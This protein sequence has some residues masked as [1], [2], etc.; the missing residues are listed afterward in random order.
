[1]KQSFFVILYVYDC[2]YWHTFETLGKWFVNT[3][4]KRFNMNFL[5]YAHWFI[6][7][8]ISQMKDHSVSVDYATCATT[9][10]AK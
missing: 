6:S 10:F 7:I 9:I 1:M 2:A 5:G 3:L 4:G 8:I